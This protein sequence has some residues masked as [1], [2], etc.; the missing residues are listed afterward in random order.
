LGVDP[1]ASAPLTH[2]LRARLA[3]TFS[4]LSAADLESA[5][6][7]GEGWCT[8]AY[9]VGPL[10]VRVPN[11]DHHAEALKL[12]PRLLPALEAAGVPLVPHG[13]TLIT[14]DDGR[15]LATAHEYVDG[16]D[17]RS[18]PRTTRGRREELARDFGRFL[19]ALHSFPPEEAVRLGVPDLDLW[20][21][22]YVPL[23]EAARPHLA[24]QTRGW[25][26]A[27]CERFVAE[28]GVP[29]SRRVLIHGDVDGRNVLLHDDGSLSGI[30]DFSDC[31]IA[32]PALDFACILNDWSWSFL[33]RVLAHYPLEVDPDARRRAAFYIAI[34]PL[35]EVREGV[36]A[37][38]PDFLRTG[39][40]KLAARARGR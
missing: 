13:M 40:A 15:I 14:G 28:G 36:E 24:T 18:L 9:R 35:W 21:D 25:L 38:R 33:E 19:G 26:D 2:E 11:S 10:V 7:L 3:A 6:V 32:D 8:V 22:H 4:F 31:M 5:E 20:A 27:L 16:V 39:R 1:E 23:I 17:A 29:E 12:E 34:A 37:G 30:I